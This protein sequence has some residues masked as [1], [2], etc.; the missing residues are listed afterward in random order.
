MKPERE[1]LRRPVRALF[2]EQLRTRKRGL[3]RRQERGPLRVQERGL[4]R[5]EER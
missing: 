2:P 5:E 3:L 1:P 4:V